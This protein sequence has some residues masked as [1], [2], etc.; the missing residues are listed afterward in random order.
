MLQFILQMHVA[1][2]GENWGKGTNL[3]GTGPYVIKE[4]D[5]QTKV[6][7][8]PNKKYH[9]KKAN[10]DRLEIVILMMQVQK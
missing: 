4:N 5:E 10:L 8:V 6:V 7:M 3:I 2:A 9:G 1:A